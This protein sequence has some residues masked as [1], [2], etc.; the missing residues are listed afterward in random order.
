[1]NKIVLI[2]INI[3]FLS[4]AF[5]EESLSC[6]I[7]SEIECADCELECE[8]YPSEA[9]ACYK[10]SIKA[11]IDFEAD[12]NESSDEEKEAL[13]ARGNQI[14]QNL[15]SDILLVKSYIPSMRQKHCLDELGSVEAVVKE[16]ESDLAEFLK[17]L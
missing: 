14:A 11:M 5:A 8:V 6:R 2:L 9:V 10:D 13:R 3:M 7:L 12:R 1:M 4:G 17:N 15:K 16:F